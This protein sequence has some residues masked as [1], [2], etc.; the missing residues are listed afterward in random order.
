MDP[1][2]FWDW[3]WYERGLREV[4]YLKRSKKEQSKLEEEFTDIPA[5]R[6]KSGIEHLMDCGVPVNE[7]GELI[8][9]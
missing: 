1:T 5:M 3:L 9:V 8:G 4:D 2:N 7:D 6:Y